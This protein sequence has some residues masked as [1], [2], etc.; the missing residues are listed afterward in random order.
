MIV[1]LRHSLPLADG[2]TS[3]SLKVHVENYSYQRN[4]EMRKGDSY[5]QLVPFAACPGEIKFCASLQE[6][7]TE[8]ARITPEMIDTTLLVNA[9][10]APAGVSATEEEEEEEATG[11]EVALDLTMTKTTRTTTEEASQDLASAP[12]TSEESSA[13]PAAAA[14]ADSVPKVKEP[15]QVADHD[16]S[17]AP[18][19]THVQKT[20]DIASTSSTVDDAEM[21][22]V[23]QPVSDN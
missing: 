13:L 11:G 15:E 8:A 17:V 7:E 1:V 2:R 19:S 12:P 16:A 6:W 18:P 20:D 22:E 21:E 4:F 5:F 9:R 14:A 3:G 10:G 23:L